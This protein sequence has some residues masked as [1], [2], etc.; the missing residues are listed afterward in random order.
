MTM[1]MN[2]RI[3]TVDDE[4][5]AQRYA[6]GRIVVIDDDADLLAALAT[7]LQMEGYACETYPSAKAYMQQLALEQPQFPG[8]SCHLCDVRMPELDG[9]A[10]QKLL[11]ERGGSPMILMSGASAIDDAVQAFR[12]GAVDFLVKPFET[13]A[14]LAAIGKALQ[15]STQQQAAC[16]RNSSLSASLATMTAREREVAVRVGE[17]QTNSEIAEAVGISLRTIK[18]YRQSA[19]EKAGAKTTAEFVRWISAAFDG[20]T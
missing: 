10:L 2:R 4:A 1:E 18:R 7:L 13:D 8:P 5:L 12:S 16:S 20:N 11:S 19:M 15:Q 17:G 14:L 6:K 9:L 3:I